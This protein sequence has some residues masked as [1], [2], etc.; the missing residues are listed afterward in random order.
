MRVGMTSMWAESLV[1]PQSSAQPAAR[2]TAGGATSALDLAIVHQDRCQVALGVD[3]RV[4]RAHPR[5]GDDRAWL[6]TS[7]GLERFVDPAQGR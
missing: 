5:L 7:V 1:A 3:A 2:G 6:P 4:A